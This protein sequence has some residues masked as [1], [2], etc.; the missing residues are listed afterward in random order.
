MRNNLLKSYQ[1][2]ASRLKGKIKGV[3]HP[4]SIDEVKTTV[5]KNLKITIRGAGTGLA[6]GAVPQNDVVLDLSKLKGI[7]KFDEK[8]KTIEAEAGVILDDLQDF[9]KKFDLEFPVKP[10]SHEVATIGGMI[11]TNAIGNR[12]V[13][14]GKTSNWVRWVDI[15]DSAGRLERKTITEMSDYVGMEG[16]SGIIVRACLKL[17]EI[18][19]RSAG[20]IRLKNLGEVEDIVRKLK[21]RQNISMIEFLDKIVSKGVGFGEG[22][23][24]IVEYEGDEG[25]LKGS[26]YR[27]VIRMR[28]E[29][30]PFVAGEGYT[31]IEDP[32]IMINKFPK[33]MGW[34]EAR[35]IPTFGHIGVGILHPCFNTNQE[36]LIPD[37]I[38]LVGRLGGQVS[39]EHGIGILKRKFV[40]I[41]DQKIIRNIKKRTDPL[42]KFN[43]GKII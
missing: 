2:D 1:S 28:D 23:H 7:G 33:L 35:G 5:L 19:E 24:L 34:L 21:R 13:K 36:K 6:G 25:S 9:L 17:N 29:V 43:T 16:I 18:R 20:I 41:N 40:E 37:M 11:A 10:S 12:G 30:Y 15:V 22:Y 8:K 27:K 14:Y 3:V 4:K 38:K 42:N 26:E 32:K 31:R 39:G